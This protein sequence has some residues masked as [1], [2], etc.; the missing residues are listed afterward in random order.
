MSGTTRFG[1]ALGTGIV[2]MAA[3]GVAV[4]LSY[5]PVRPRILCAMPLGTGGYA[6]YFGYT[7]ESDELVVEPRGA[8]NRVLP[9]G[10]PTTSFAPGSSGSYPNAAFV[11]SARAGEEVAWTLG[12]RTVRLSE[13]TL[14]CPIPTL[15]E[16][17]EDVAWV[18]PKP[19]VIEP[20]PP[21]EPEP[22]APETPPEPKVEPPPEPVA[23]KPPPK[24]PERKAPR[25]K[26]KK[27]ITAIAT[28]EAPVALALTGLTNMGSGMAIQKGEV[29]SLGDASVKADE[30]TNRV[31]DAG[32]LGGVEG[33]VPG[34]T[35]DVKPPKR[36]PARVKTRPKGEW[37]VDA[38]PRA[39][40]VLVR[41]SLL[42]GTDGKVKQVKV[43]RGAGA[44]FDREARAVGLRALFSPATVDDEP[45]ESW[46]PWDVEFTPDD[47]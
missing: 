45:V 13:E 22:P 43:I 15:S 1:I 41:L 28:V 6:V 19:A 26:P 11:V 33:G 35:L 21:P 42:V 46:V 9:G 40:S 32:A 38:P 10:E 8:S 31:I 17:P 34:G 44:A 16:P 3:L 5:H 36:T 7:N 14:R 20:T 4:A 24:P 39:G 12:P 37:P 30:R 47:F 29:D 23:T 25:P 27:E 2:L 18:A